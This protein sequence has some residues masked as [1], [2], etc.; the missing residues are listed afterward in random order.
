MSPELRAK[1]LLCVRDYGPGVAASVRKRIFQPFVTT[2]IGQGGTGLGL[3]IVHNIVVNVLRGRIE[4]DDPEGG[5]TR[6][7]I[8]LP[9]VV[10]RRDDEAS[11]AVS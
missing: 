3:A 11:L 2:G 7:I 4:L 1:L 10:P 5:G 8:E 6:F 9:A